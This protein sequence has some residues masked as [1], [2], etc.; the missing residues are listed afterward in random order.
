M[1]I[2][3]IALD[4]L[5]EWMDSYFHPDEDEDGPPLLIRPATTGDGWATFLVEECDPYPSSG[6]LVR[7]RVTAEEVTED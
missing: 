1:D 2:G 3:E 7:V 6:R 4:V 5:V